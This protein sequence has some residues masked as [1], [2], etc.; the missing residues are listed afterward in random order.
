MTVVENITVT[1][2]RSCALGEAYIPV[3]CKNWKLSILARR[4]VTKCSHSVF[5][6]R[7]LNMNKK[8]S[9]V[10]QTIAKDTA[11]TAFLLG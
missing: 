4:Q 10:F 11:D 9:H 7:D 1:P 5:S 2:L 8:P 6:C 3:L